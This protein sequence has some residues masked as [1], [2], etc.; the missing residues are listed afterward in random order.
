[1]KPNKANTPT[2]KVV[3]GGGDTIGDVNVHVSLPELRD[4]LLE[5]P[6]HLP[7]PQFTIPAP[8]INIQAPPSPE[9]NIQ[10]PEAHFHVPSPE[11]HVS[12]PQVHIEPTVVNVAP[13][14]V[15]ITQEAQPIEFKA[16]PVEIRLDHH[17]MHKGML[18]SL[19][20]GLYFMLTLNLFLVAFVLYP[21]FK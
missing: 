21:M 7:I 8:I 15:N 19:V 3:G 1:M 17:I 16:A 13:A 20:V 6:R 12:A 5:L 10:A 14:V 9:I 18:I 2:Y 11:V 4:V